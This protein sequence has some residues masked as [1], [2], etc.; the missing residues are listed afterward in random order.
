MN[1]RKTNLNPWLDFI[2]KVFSEPMEL[3][4]DLP[5]VSFINFTF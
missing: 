3:V 1:N 5:T 2:L 4:L